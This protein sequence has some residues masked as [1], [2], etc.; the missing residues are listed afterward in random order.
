MGNDQA[1]AM[2]AELHDRIIKAYGDLKTASAAMGIPYK[3]LYRALT[4]TGKDRVAS[5]SLDFIVEAVDHLQREF[6]GDDLGA[7]YHAA[8]R[9][10]SYALAASDDEQWKQSQE[11]GE[12]FP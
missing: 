9:R 1:D 2:R 7:V 4:K 6:G 10:E 11:D 3:T 8:L 5:V 12:E